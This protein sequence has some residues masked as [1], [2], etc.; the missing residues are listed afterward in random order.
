MSYVTYDD[1]RN[2]Q[3]SKHLGTGNQAFDN[4]YGSSLSQIMAQVGG[5]AQPQFS[6][7]D[8]PALKKLMASELVGGINGEGIPAGVTPDQIL[9]HFKQQG[10]WESKDDNS[11]LLGQV[12]ELGG[13]VAW[14]GASALG[15]PVA[16]TIAAANG[17]GATQGLGIDPRLTTAA[18]LAYG[19][20]N[21]NPFGSTPDANVA[22]SEYGAN[23]SGTING[24][25]GSGGGAGGNVGNSYFD[26]YGN[27]LDFT[28]SGPGYSEADYTSPDGFS[29]NPSTADLGGNIDPN[30]GM[31]AGNGLMDQAAAMAKKYGMPILS[32]ARMLG[33][34]GKTIIG[35]LGRGAPAALGVIGANNQATSLKD[36]ADKYM[37]LG[38]PS[39]DRYEASFAPGFTMANDPGYTDAL[40]M[41]S[42]ANLHGL[43]TQGNP[44]LSPNAQSQNMSDLY[45]K[46]A[47]PALQNY[48]ATN[49]N[50][51]GISTLT[52]AAPGAASGAITAQ[53]NV[54]NAAGA[55]L[56]DIF[57]PTPS[58]AQTLAQYQQLMKSQTAVAP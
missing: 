13:P 38:A 53:G 16:G 32:A 47:Y 15:G 1:W 46:T 19:A 58:L 34:D 31:P 20:Y 4:A 55:G 41:A 30:T 5:G 14:L 57:N 48:R 3:L 12:K 2:A 28:P 56:N 10:G 35:A 42:K 11:G 22:G 29:T 50:A 23:S 40:D 49:S 52:G 36:L 9:E 17:S 43:S 45:M 37:A 21:S 44:A 54:F 25:T 24:V 6:G 33:I 8:D 7:A 26:D 51:G 18:G 39:R 27:P